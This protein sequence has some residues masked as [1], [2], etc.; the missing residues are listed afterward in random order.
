MLFYSSMSRY[1]SLRYCILL[2]YCTVHCCLIFCVLLLV[3]YVYL[4]VYIVLLTL[5]PGVNPIAVNKYLS[6]VS[7]I[8]CSL[9]MKRYHNSLLHT[10]KNPQLDPILNSY[11]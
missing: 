7:E 2:F 5:P 10:H 11:N 1:N 9:R 8:K 6:K 3:I 4:T